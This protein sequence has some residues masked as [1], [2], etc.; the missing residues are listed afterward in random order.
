V[1][2][3]HRLPV[4]HK[5]ILEANLAKNRHGEEGGFQIEFDMPRQNMWELG[6]NE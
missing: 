2:L 3:L 5:V 1:L 4:Q 6:S